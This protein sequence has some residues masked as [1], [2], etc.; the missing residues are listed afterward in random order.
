VGSREAISWIVCGTIAAVLVGLV[1]FGGGGADSGGSGGGADATAEIK[2]MLTRTM[3]E[4][5]PQQCTHDMTPAFLEQSFGRDEDNTAPENCREENTDDEPPSARS[6]AFQSV[7]V[8]GSTAEAVVAIE[9]GNM[10]GSRVTVRLVSDAGRWKLDRLA[11]LQID[12]ARVDQAY[13]REMEESGL[14]RAEARCVVA[15]LHREFSDA[16][17]ERAAVSGEDDLATDQ[18]GLECV[19]R[20]TLVAM[21]QKGIVAGAESRGMPSSVADCVAQRFTSGLSDAELRAFVR[22]HRTQRQAA[23]L[24]AVLAACATAYRSG[25]LPQVGSS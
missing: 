12:R 16:E 4:N 25:A 13:V 20:S 2:Q 18:V 10:D 3:T 19:S 5:D 21:F 9:G 24:R 15:E 7:T 17:I 6:V 1:L 11:D 14:S 8:Q 22:G 23:E